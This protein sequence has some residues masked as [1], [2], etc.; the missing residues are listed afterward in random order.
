MYACIVS[1]HIILSTIIF[2][3]YLIGASGHLCA[4][5]FTCLIFFFVPWFFS[6]WFLHR[7]V[8]YKM[9]YLCS[10]ASIVSK[11]LVWCEVSFIIIFLVV[12][13][14][15]ASIADIK[16]SKA[17]LL[18]RLLLRKMGMISNCSNPWNAPLEKV[19]ISFSYLNRTQ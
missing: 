3:D 13:F 8:L 19:P 16:P 14:H 5:I 18:F 11:C 4:L 17:A 9:I 12:S 10:S 15:P 7:F 2:L 1:F 6:W